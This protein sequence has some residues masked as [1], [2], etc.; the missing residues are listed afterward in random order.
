VVVVVGA[1]RA[2][3][4]AVL[5]AV[6]AAAAAQQGRTLVSVALVSRQVGLDRQALPMR[7]VLAAAARSRVAPGA[8]P[9]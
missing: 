5:S 6:S 8:A 1:V 4:V 2:A 7:A 3:A 9:P